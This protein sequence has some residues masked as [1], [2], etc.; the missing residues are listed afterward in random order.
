MGSI[1][2][3]VLPRCRDTGWA[4]E[5]HRNL[6]Q[7]GT[8]D[9]GGKAA[10]QHRPFGAEETQQANLAQQF[11]STQQQPLP[12]GRKLWVTEE[13]LQGGAWRR[14]I[15]LH[16]GLPGGR[17]PLVPLPASD[18]QTE[19]GFENTRSLPALL[20]PAGE[21]TP[22]YTTSQSRLA[23]PRPALSHFMHICPIGAFRGTDQICFFPR[24]LLYQP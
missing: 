4:G 22:P 9:S 1:A 20:C 21:W 3:T 11:R 24:K 5:R 14:R 18:A 10:R 12:E 16:R 23:R 17:N 6:Q 2:G 8:S 7:A 15:Q 13:L 19:T